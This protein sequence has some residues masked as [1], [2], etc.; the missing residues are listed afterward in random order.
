MEAVCLKYKG[1]DTK[2]SPRGTHIFFING[3]A[4]MYLC[5]LISIWRHVY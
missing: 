3:N 1:P 4:E 5:S 2:E